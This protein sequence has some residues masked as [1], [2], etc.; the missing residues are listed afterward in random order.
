MSDASLAELQSRMEGLETRSVY[1]DEII[2]ALN[3]VVTVQQNQIDRLSAEVARLREGLEALAPDGIDPG[4]EPP[5]PH[6]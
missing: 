1:Q 4:E 3:E 5:P 2:D 6:Y